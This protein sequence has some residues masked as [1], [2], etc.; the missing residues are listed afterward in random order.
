MPN[1]A[2]INPTTSPSRVPL[3]EM[4]FQVDRNFHE[5]RSLCFGVD[6]LADTEDLRHIAMVRQ[7]SAIE[8]RQAPVADSQAAKQVL[9][10]SFSDFCWEVEQCRHINHRFDA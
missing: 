7:E 8:T 1:I 10:Y 3:A 6:L 5:E 9:P 2:W 4:R